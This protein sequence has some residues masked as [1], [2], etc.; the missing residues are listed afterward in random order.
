M[1]K[2]YKKPTI[3]TVLLHYWRKDLGARLL[4]SL[5][6]FAILLFVS[7]SI[8]NAVY[9]YEDWRCLTADCKILKSTDKEL[10]LMGD[11]L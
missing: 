10:L 2:P 5:V 7:F 1:A 8:F 11:S 6:L 9:V 4:M 3:G